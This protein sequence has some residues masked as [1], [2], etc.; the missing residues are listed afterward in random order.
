LSNESLN[1]IADS[2]AVILGLPAIRDGHVY[3]P[4]SSEKLSFGE[5]LSYCRKDTVVFGGG[6][7]SDSLALAENLKIKCKDYL[8]D[9]IFALE[10]ALYTA[11]GAL[12]EII[13]STD[14]SLCGMKILVA[15][16]GRIARALCSLVAN[17][18]CITDVYARS[19]IQ[20]TFFE[21]RGNRTFDILPPLEG[22][23]V[24][25]N[26]VPADIFSRSALESAGGKPLVVDLS[27]RPGYVC[28]KTCAELGIKLLYLPGIPLKSAPRSAGISAAMA[29]WRMYAEVKN[30]EGI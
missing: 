9:E 23:D 1:E 11:E 3:M 22:Y 13:R 12:S 17:A 18:P 8:K 19:G 25:V 29:V 26:T 15:G 16:G 2:D 30:T 14:M 28:Q 10:N 21:M 6:F 7:K 4:L 24:V 5:L 20:R 27:A